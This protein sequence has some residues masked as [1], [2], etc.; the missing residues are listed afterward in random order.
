MDDDIQVI[1]GRAINA[2]YWDDCVLNSVQ[3]NFYALHWYLNIICPRWKG[4]VIKNDSGNYRGVMPLPVRKKAG[5]TY[6]HQPLF[7]Q[8]LG[9]YLTFAPTM[10]VFSNI[11]LHLVRDFKYISKYTFS[12]ENQLYT[13]N[14]S[15]HF[16]KTTRYTHHLAL[17]K[18]Y[19]QLKKSYTRDRRYNLK[20]AKKSGVK[21]IESTD[22]NPLIAMFKESTSHKIQGGVDASVYGLLR[23]ICVAI[24]SRNM[25]KLLYTVDATT[26]T[27]QSGALFVRYA[28]KIVYLFNAA[29]DTYR[30]NNG[31]TLLID[32]IIKENQSTNNV[33]DFESPS[34][35]SVCNFYKSFGSSAMPFDE[36]SLNNLPFFLK[37]LQAVKLKLVHL[38]QGK[39]QL[40]AG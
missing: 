11:Q 7:A 18:P 26:N 39:T 14:F 4:L 38:W 13:K 34:L 3:G 16:G 19:E 35:A 27:Y 23:Q 9:L 30:N 31:R 17:N 10:Q 22:P 28:K 20:Q 24:F 12:I 33:L 8:Q 40:S 25:G 15:E 1:E 5:F 2:Q 36:I 32:T 29:F 37:H 21:I 6:L